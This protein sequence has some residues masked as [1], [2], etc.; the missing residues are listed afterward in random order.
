MLIEELLGF[1]EKFKQIT[2]KRSQKPNIHYVSERDKNYH[3]RNSTLPLYFSIGPVH[4]G[5]LDL[6]IGESGK[7]MH[8]AML[9]CEMTSP[10]DF[11]KECLEGLKNMGADRNI[12]VFYNRHR[13]L[14]NLSKARLLKMDLLDASLVI[15]FIMKS[16]SWNLRIF[17]RLMVSR[18]SCSYLHECFISI[19]LPFFN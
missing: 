17:G 12:L 2:K 11:L 13:K 10:Q 18:I 16:Q 19:N 9:I 7:A 3:T 5:D 14:R 8:L 15:S 4:N 1:L 6:Q